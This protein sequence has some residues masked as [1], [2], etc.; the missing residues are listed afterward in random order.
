M[1]ES[2]CSWRFANPRLVYLKWKW[3][4]FFTVSRSAGCEVEGSHSPGFPLARE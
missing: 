4:V 3:A 1:K 2:S